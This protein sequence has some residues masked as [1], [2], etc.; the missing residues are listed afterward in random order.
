[1]ERSHCRGRGKRGGYTDAPTPENALE[2]V[3]NE[4]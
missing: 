2:L 4:I 1:M 3:M